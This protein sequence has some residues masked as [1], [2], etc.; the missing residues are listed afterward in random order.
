[1][2]WCGVGVVAEQSIVTPFRGVAKCVNPVLVE[3]QSH[4]IAY[5]V[6]WEVM[7]SILSVN[8]SACT[9]RRFCHP[10]A[11]EQV[12]SEVDDRMGVDDKKG[13]HAPLSVL[14]LPSVYVLFRDALIQS[15]R[16][17]TT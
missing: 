10:Y 8:R 13:C 1:M 15:T 6:A 16:L 17:S 14:A 12:Q 5:R 11:R 9:L 7:P 3:E 4:D 2:V